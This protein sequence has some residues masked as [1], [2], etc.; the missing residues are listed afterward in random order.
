M[1][2]GVHIAYL[3]GNFDMSLFVLVLRSLVEK[4]VNQVCLSL[5][6]NQCQCLVMCRVMPQYQVYFSYSFMV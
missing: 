5:V 1:E 3:L 4:G 2:N 6:Q